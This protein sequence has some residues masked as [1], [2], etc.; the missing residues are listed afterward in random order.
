MPASEMHREK[1][2]WMQIHSF[3][4]IIRAIEKYSLLLEEKVSA[5]LTDEV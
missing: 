3:S 5:Q 1:K 4:Y 2:E